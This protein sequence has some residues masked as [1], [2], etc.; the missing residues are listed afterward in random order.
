MS[1]SMTRTSVP[2]CTRASSVVLTS[3]VFCCLGQLSR[4]QVFTA[5]HH[6]RVD[7]CRSSDDPSWVLEHLGTG[8]PT[9]A[10]PQCDVDLSGPARPWRAIRVPAGC[11]I[12]ACSSAP[13]RDPTVL[14]LRPSPLSRLAPRS[15]RLGVFH[16]PTPRA[17]GKLDILNH[18]QEAEKGQGS[19]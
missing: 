12:L 8:E 14:A 15:P 4:G 3:P 11:W 13:A 16:G 18:I 2:S 10:Q 5:L 1:C 7:R 19:G 6:L 9:A 17:I